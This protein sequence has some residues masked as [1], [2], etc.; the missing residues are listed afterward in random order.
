MYAIRS[1]YVQEVNFAYQLANFCFVLSVYDNEV[2]GVIGVRPPRS[3]SRK[4][5]AF[6]I[7]KE[8]TLDSDGKIIV[9]GSGLP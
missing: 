3:S 9:N 7:G 2:D 8:P 5:I 6:W 4:D 1:Y